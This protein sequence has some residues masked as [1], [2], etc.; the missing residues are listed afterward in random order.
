MNARWYMA[1]LL[2]GS[3]VLLQG[4]TIANAQQNEGPILKPKNP[5]PNC[6]DGCSTR[7]PETS[8]TPSSQQGPT[9]QET[10]AFMN[11]MV[12]PEDGF[13]NSVNDCELSAVRNKNQLF[14]LVTSTY[15]KS[16][17][18]YG[19]EHYGFKW[20]FYADSPRFVRFKLGDID[21]DSI[22][23]K[24]Q[25]SLAFV[26]EHDLDEHPAELENPDLDV[27]D[28]STRNLEKNIE[29]GS[30]KDIGDGKNVSPVFDQKRALDFFVFESKDR[31][32]RFVTAFVYAVKVCGGK[33]GMFP[34]TP[35]KP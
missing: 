23:S 17:D 34:P 19:I 32:E 33:G 4:L 2:V 14:G 1:K 31:A 13:I 10:I 7:T 25:P 22:R 24:P 3:S 28:F 21:P 11:T 15:V 20:S 30:I 8:G 12:A 26:K 18:E 16:K 35:S 6:T 29:I 27:V 9:L 5:T